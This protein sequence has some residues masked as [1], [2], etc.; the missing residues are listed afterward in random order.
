MHSIRRR[1]RLLLPAVCVIAACLGAVPASGVSWREL[2]P[3]GNGSLVSAISVSTLFTNAVVIGTS[4]GVYVSADSGTSWT[5]RNSGLSGPTTVDVGVEPNSSL[6]IYAV[7]ESGLFKTI[8]GGATW[9]FSGSGL[10]SGFS[11]SKV[12][13]DQNVPSIVYVGTTGAGLFRSQD[14]GASWV[15]VNTGLQS[16]SITAV[17]VVSCADNIV[18]AGT[19]EGLYRSFDRGNSWGKVY[20]GQG[21]GASAIDIA[22]G[23]NG[24]G[25]AVFVSSAP[26]PPEAPA[27]SYLVASSD[28]GL[29]WTR[30]TSGL[31]DFGLSTVAISPTSTSVVDVGDNGSGV[32][33]SSDAGASWSSVNQGL[34]NLSVDSL[35]F[36]RAGIL[37]AG[38]FGGGVFAQDASPTPCVAD[39]SSLCLTGGRF[40]VRVD[41]A[42]ASA[43]ASGPAH[44]VRLSNTAGYFW[45][46]DASTPE[47]TVKI[48]DGRAFN[49]KFWLFYGSLS[50]VQYTVTVVDTTT[51]ASRSYSNPQG[52]LASVADTAAF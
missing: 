13:V 9:R 52:H 6:T 45:F 34:T 31:P 15:A 24:P 48:I 42:A 32:F 28:G 12:S 44:S 37:Y 49:E 5:P 43:D 1:R 35:S 25:F 29:H 47:V 21:F 36:D 10:P 2:G 27:A 22:P 18:F 46:F 8:D 19:P 16:L 3:A 11:V 38:T 30:V 51:G 4:N 20:D 26:K 7:T 39:G 14:G 33:E 17:H 50:D 40:R 41:W 23:G